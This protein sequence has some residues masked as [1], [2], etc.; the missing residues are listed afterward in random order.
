MIQRLCFV[1]SLMLISNA[2]LAQQGKSQGNISRPDNK[3]LAG[4]TISLEGRAKA[5]Q[6]DDNGNFLFNGIVPGS[7][8]IIASGIGY[9][10]KSSQV[11]VEDGKTTFLRLEL[12]IATSTLKEV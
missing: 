5:T 12:D 9:Q 1:L 4:I 11:K 8:V 7:Y 6:T 3:V 10:A 2:L